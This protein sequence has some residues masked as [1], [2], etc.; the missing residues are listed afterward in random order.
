M[1]TG[2]QA[3][4]AMIA[5]SEAARVLQF[6]LNARVHYISF[7]ADNG[8]NYPLN[9]ILMLVQKLFP[10]FGQSSPREAI[11]KTP[12]DKDYA[13][14]P[15]YDRAARDGEPYKMSVDGKRV[16]LRTKYVFCVAV[17]RATT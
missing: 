12:G 10:G 16:A 15:A 2:L 13:Q 11:D 5:E 17:V 7:I 6:I 4:D 14:H 3:V 9:P 8:A 1:E